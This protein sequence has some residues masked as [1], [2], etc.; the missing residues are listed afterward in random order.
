MKARSPS[1]QTALVLGG[2]G[3]AG[4]AW[5]VGL[6]VGLSRTGRSLGTADL[7]IGTSAGA[8]VAACL[9]A[10]A[11]PED[12]FARQIAPHIDEELWMPFSLAEISS[13]NA[14]LLR[15]VSGDL[16]EARRRVGRY[17]AAATTPDAAERLA[18]IQSRIRDARWTDRDLRIVATNVKNGE[19]I[20]LTTSSGVALVQAVA[21]SSAVPGTWPPVPL[22]ELVGMDGGVV[23]LANADLAVEAEAIA[24]VSPMGYGDENPLSG[25]LR[26]EIDLL[27]RLGRRVTA[28]VPDRNSLSAMGDNLLD[29]AGRRPAAEAG[30]QQGMT[31]ELSWP[32]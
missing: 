6:L 26:A 21:A 2:G 31:E 25:H 23:S 7:L 8:S 5:A 4:I 17:A 9:A 29:P 15:K 22:G 32:A 11:E 24:V 19:R 3:V 30:L 12:L 16:A 18:S 13:R 27:R 28:V 10:G 1:L 14:E 20:V